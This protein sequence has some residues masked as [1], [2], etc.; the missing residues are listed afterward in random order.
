MLPLARRCI[1]ALIEEEYGR[2]RHDGL[3]VARELA[4]AGRG[5]ARSTDNT[6]VARGPVLLRAPEIAAL[7]LCPATT[8]VGLMVRSDEVVARSPKR[9]SSIVCDAKRRSACGAHN[10][11]S[12]YGNA[13]NWLLLSRKMAL[14]PAAWDPR[15]RAS[16]PTISFSVPLR[17]APG[18]ELVG[19][20][21][22]HS[23]M[24][25][26]TMDTQYVQ[27]GFHAWCEQ[28]SGQAMSSPFRM[29]VIGICRTA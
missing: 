27:W 12:L 24:L 14:A 15:W 22:G 1:E 29:A 25:V 11:N 9:A 23:S 21:D 5:D 10:C 28:W 20:Y 8:E 26:Q 16:A 7:S 19:F 4:C 18:A 13:R 2:L 6:G 17:W 3:E